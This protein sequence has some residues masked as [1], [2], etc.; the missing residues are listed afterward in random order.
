VSLRA[1][2]AVGANVS[3]S[4]RGSVEVRG[5]AMTLVSQS[6]FVVGATSGVEVTATGPVLMQST[7]EITLR[8]T[9]DIKLDSPKNLFEMIHAK[10]GAYSMAM[11]L[12]GIKMDV[13]FL[14]ADEHVCKIEKGSVKLGDLGANLSKAITHIIG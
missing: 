7:G 14:K 2:A 5:Q 12:Y 4:A 6:N 1:P 3:V 13:G 9:Q 8:S 11:T 10:I